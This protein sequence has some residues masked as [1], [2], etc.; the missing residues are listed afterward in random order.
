MNDFRMR[1]F[2]M[3]CP[4]GLAGFPQLSIPAGSVENG[5][6]GLSFVGHKNQ[7]IAVIELAAKIQLNH[8]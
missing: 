2:E 1:A 3:L 5:P 4:A 6:V 7:D 8:M